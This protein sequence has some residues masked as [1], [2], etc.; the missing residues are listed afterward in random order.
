MIEWLKLINVTWNG[1]T[2]AGQKTS[3]SGSSH[4]PR[5]HN[6]PNEPQESTED[7]DRGQYSCCQQ[8]VASRIWKEKEYE[9]Y[10]VK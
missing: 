1:E 4:I 6:S 8:P 2:D 9:T 5:E 3:T 7:T 10:M